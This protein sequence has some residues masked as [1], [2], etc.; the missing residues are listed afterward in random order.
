MSGC[1]RRA[2]HSLSFSFFLCEMVVVHALHV[3]PGEKAGGCVGLACAALS[4]VGPQAALCLSGLAPSLPPQ[5]FKA[6]GKPQLLRLSREGSCRACSSPAHRVR[7]G[8]GPSRR[9]R[10]G[11]TRQHINPRATGISKGCSAF[12]GGGSST[13]V[14]ECLAGWHNAGLVLHC[15]VIVDK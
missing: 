12:C 7:D 14:L 5:P 10:L 6:K 15:P 13:D 9:C 3:A 8:E 1:L 11:G 4:T 2:L